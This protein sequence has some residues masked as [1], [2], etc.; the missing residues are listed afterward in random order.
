M[1]KLIQILR[2]A[3]LEELQ[4]FAKTQRSDETVVNITLKTCGGFPILIC[5]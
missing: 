3:L 2:H 5:P 4:G 1:V